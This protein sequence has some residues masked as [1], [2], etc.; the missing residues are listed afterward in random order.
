MGRYSPKPQRLVRSL[1]EVFGH[2]F[3]RVEKPRPRSTNEKPDCAVDASRFLSATSADAGG[4]Y[5]LTGDIRLDRA[6]WNQH[7]ISLVIRLVGE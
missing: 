1:K 5:R 6:F 3:A 2:G 4:Q 7:G